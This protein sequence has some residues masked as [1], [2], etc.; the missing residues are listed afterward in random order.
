MT[1]IFS[2][3]KVQETKSGPVRG[4]APRKSSA[5]PRPGLSDSY[6]ILV[7]SLA[8]YSAQFTYSYSIR[9]HHGSSRL[10]VGSQRART[11]SDA[12][13]VPRCALE[14][15]DELQDSPLTPR[16]TDWYDNEH[17]PLRMGK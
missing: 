14:L 3:D 5:V 10:L 17:V 16:F 7:P 15:R 4:I 6:R 2:R 13:R 12:R 8:C 1:Y 9:D 11:V